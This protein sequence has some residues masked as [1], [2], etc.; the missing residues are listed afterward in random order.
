ML[1]SII[2]PKKGANA[3]N[4]LFNEN[5]RFKKQNKELKNEIKA[6]KNRKVVKLADKI[7]SRKVL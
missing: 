6:F 1:A 5:R 4:N 3:F 2:T 7:K